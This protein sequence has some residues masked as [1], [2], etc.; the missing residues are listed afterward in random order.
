MRWIPFIYLIAMCLVQIRWATRQDIA[1]ADRIERFRTEIVSLGM[2]SEMAK[3]FADTIN[4]VKRESQSV[5][6]MNFMLLWMPLLFGSVIW[7]KRKT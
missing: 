3:E 2:S 7:S 4:E 6:N 5:T 1:S